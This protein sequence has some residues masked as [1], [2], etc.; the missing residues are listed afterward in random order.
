MYHTLFCLTR[1]SDDTSKIATINSNT[2]EL[3]INLNINATTAD[4]FQNL[5]LSVTVEASDGTTVTTVSPKIQ[6]DACV[7][8]FC[9]CCSYNES[10]TERELIN[11]SVI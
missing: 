7:V 8:R 4:D 6:I 11:P 1:L 9:M 3:T 2:G 10:V 5:N